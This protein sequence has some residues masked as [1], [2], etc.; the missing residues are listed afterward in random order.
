M[1]DVVDTMI[2]NH[3]PFRVANAFIFTHGR[4]KA[5]EKKSGCA[6]RGGKR[7]AFPRNPTEKNE[8]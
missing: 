5:E 7:L 1:R 8:A 2:E 4:R 3:N 6:F